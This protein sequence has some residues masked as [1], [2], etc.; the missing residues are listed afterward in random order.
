MY[1]Y[2]YFGLS[3]YPISY[4]M[5]LLS[6]IILTLHLSLNRY[7]PLLPLSSAKQLISKLFLKLFQS[8]NTAIFLHLICYFYFKATYSSTRLY[9]TYF[10]GSVASKSFLGICFCYKYSY[11]ILL[12]FKLSNFSPGLSTQ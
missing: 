5:C 6:L 2:K 8:L 3:R 12:N 11:I 4:F 1:L 9:S 10:L 7:Q